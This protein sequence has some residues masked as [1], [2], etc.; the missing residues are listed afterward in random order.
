MSDSARW[1]HSP[2]RPYI[3]Q[4]T[5]LVSISPGRA[6]SHQLTPVLAM[7]LWHGISGANGFRRNAPPTAR[8]L[9]FNA[10]DIAA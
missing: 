4:Q 1:V 5:A 9:L 8:G 10:L 7:H 3:H 2:S 6:A